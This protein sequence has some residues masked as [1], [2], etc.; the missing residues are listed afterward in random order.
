MYY[1]LPWPRRSPS[2]AFQHDLI[3]HFFAFTTKQTKWRQK[4]LMRWQILTNKVM[5]INPNHRRTEQP[6]IIDVPFDWP[7]IP[8]NPDGSNNIIPKR[9]V[10]A[11]VVIVIH[12]TTVKNH[13]N[14]FCFEMQNQVVPK[15]GEPRVTSMIMLIAPTKE[16]VLN[17]TNKMYPSR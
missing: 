9:Y 1:M 13:M 12:M 16:A 8:P 10:I 5:Q 7:C 2:F 3:I 11:N 17:A 6:T 14:S 4:Q 15:L